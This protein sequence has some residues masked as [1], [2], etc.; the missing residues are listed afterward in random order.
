MIECNYCFFFSLQNNNDRVQLFARMA[1]N[2]APSFK[3]CIHVRLFRTPEPYMSFFV[4]LSI[5]RAIQSWHLIAPFFLFFFSIRNCCMLTTLWVLIKKK[6]N[7][8]LDILVY[9]EV[10]CNKNY[11]LDILV[12]KTQ[13]KIWVCSN[14]L[15][16]NS[17]MKFSSG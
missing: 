7:Y 3:P 13:N 17:A 6:K 16:Y 4:K 12:T 15:C 8:F 9:I 11:F 2:T 1:C 14:L 10:I 5:L